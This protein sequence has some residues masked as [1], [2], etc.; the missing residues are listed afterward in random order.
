MKL[1]IK[2]QIKNNSLI[3]FIFKQTNDKVFNLEVYLDEV[4]LKDE[5]LWQTNNVIIIKK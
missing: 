2:F 1:S 3:C 5:R 4:G